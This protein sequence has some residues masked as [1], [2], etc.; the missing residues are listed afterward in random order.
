LEAS[1]AI[2]IKNIFFWVMTADW[3]IF[4]D[5][6]EKSTAPFLGHPFTLKLYAAFTS[7]TS[8]NTY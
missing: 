8:V 4:T 2:N 6:T 7:E 1:A 3:Q 5:A